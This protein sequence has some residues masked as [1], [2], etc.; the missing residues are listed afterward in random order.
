MLSRATAAPNVRLWL[1]DLAN[2]YVKKAEAALSRM[3]AP[4]SIALPNRRHDIADAGLDRC[5]DSRTSRV[6]I[7]ATDVLK[8]SDRALRVLDAHPRRNVAKGAST[9]SSVAG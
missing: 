8:V 3:S 5:S 6:S 2:D 1:T 4:L 7:V 9:S